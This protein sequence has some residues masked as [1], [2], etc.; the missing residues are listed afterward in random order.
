MRRVP[1]RSPGNTTGSCVDTRTFA[2]DRF[3]CLIRVPQFIDTTHSG[4][5]GALV[6]TSIR[7]PNLWA[8]NRPSPFSPRGRRPL[9][10]RLLSARCCARWSCPGTSHISRM[11]SSVIPTPSSSMM[12]DASELSMFCK[13]TLTIC[14]SASYAF[15]TSSKTARRGEPIS[16]S[17]RSCRSRALGLKGSFNP[18]LPVF[19]MALG[20]FK[21]FI[22]SFH[23]VAPPICHTGISIWKPFT[24]FPYTATLAACEP[25]VSVPAALPQRVP[26]PR[27]FQM[28]PMDILSVKV[29]KEPVLGP[30]SSTG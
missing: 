24:E 18:L 26:N 3:I 11:V 17:P 12:I 20:V 6:T 14:A 22:P 8:A 2:S 10:V 25:N 16:S 5:P 13:T 23:I 19:V 29:Q 28:L 27:D 4:C 9:G 30:A 7:F 15:F 21:C 1:V